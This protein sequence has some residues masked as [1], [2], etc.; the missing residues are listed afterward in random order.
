MDENSIKE[1][2]KELKENGQKIVQQINQTQQ[3]INQLQTLLVENNGRI[4]E[5]KNLNFDSNPTT[6]D[7]DSETIKTAEVSNNNG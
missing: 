5:L 6:T 4:K 7:I 3:Q 1:R 2:I